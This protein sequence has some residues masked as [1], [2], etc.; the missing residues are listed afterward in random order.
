MRRMVTS[1]LFWFVMAGFIVFWLPA[2]FL[3]PKAMAEAASGI[4]LAVFTAVAG[5]WFVGFIAGLRDRPAQGKWQLVVS[6]FGVAAFLAM[7]RLWSI[8]W[9]WMDYPEWMVNS[10]V[11]AFLVWGLAVFGVLQLI[12]PG[13][14]TGVVPRKNLWVTTIAVAVGAAV[15]GFMVARYVVPH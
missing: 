2:P 6:I 13:N 11:Q 14:E 5:T 4:A 3:G 8:A 7:I 12:S 10:Y 9:R 1:R 15:A